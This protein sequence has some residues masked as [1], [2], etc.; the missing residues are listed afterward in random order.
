MKDKIIR[1]FEK[2][3]FVNNIQKNKA[4]NKLVFSVASMNYK[5]NKYDNKLFLYDEDK[6]SRLKLFNSPVIYKFIDNH[7]LIYSVKSE[8]IKKKSYTKIYI[9]GINSRKYSQ[10]FNIPFEISDFYMVDARYLVIITSEKID[11]NIEKEEFKHEITR[12]NFVEN[13][14]SYTYNDISRAY[15]YDMEQNKLKLISNV[16]ESI[17]FVNIYD[18]DIYFITNE[19]ADVYTPYSKLYIHNIDE[20]NTKTL[21]D[22]M[23]FEISEVYKI[24]E[25]VITLASDMKIYGVNENPKFYKLKGEKLELYCNNEYSMGNSTNSDLRYKIASRT[26]QIGDSLYFLTT[27]DDKSNIY[28]LSNQKIEK[29]FDDVNIV[30]D[31]EFLDKSLLICGFDK[32]NMQELYSYSLKNMAYDLKSKTNI[33]NFSSKFEN[34]ISSYKLE[35]FEF[36]SNDDKLKGYVIYPK[37]FDK[38]IKYP[39]VLCIHG[40]P[41]TV[42]SSNFFYEMYLLSQ[43][44][45]FVFYTN[46]HGSCG[47]NNDFA[48]IRGKYG[49]IDYD[50]LMNLTDE[51]LKRYQSIDKSR[52][53]VMGGSYGGYMT[54]HIIGQTDRFKTAITQRSISN[55][56][57]F[58]GTSDIGYYFATDQ[59]GCEYEV[60]KLWE[61]SPM[62]NVDKIKTPLLIIH[63]DQDYRCP[64][65]QALQLF[66]RLKINKLKSK[67]LIYNGENH[68]LSRSGKVQSRV[69]RLEQILLWLRETL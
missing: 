1:D 64:L 58:Y 50:D 10:S 28:L 54:N 41:K 32:H 6:I 51:V 43:S 23:D 52:L 60:E 13:G 22:K 39:A 59:N 8:K 21:Y 7:Q 55:W 30:D 34:A 31:F 57:S 66:T 40:G 65:E 42:Y 24:R 44:G 67:M 27:R 33:T 9:Q 45:Y 46:P 37:D 15:V 63:S 4:G 25:D 18:R 2:M 5:K 29:Y 68:D 17:S 19:K 48:D 47:R 26:K 35:E 62:K 53:A 14:A 12:V 16:N 3:R 38:N 11:E 49:T 36:S 56:V 20:N 61:K 69:S